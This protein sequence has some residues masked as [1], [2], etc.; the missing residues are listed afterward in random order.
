MFNLFCCKINN[1][2]RHKLVDALQDWCLSCIESKLHSLSPSVLSFKIPFNTNLQG[3][4]SYLH[5]SSTWGLWFCYTK[6]YTD[7]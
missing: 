4:W 3:Q 2:V 6:S 1:T 7:S 5:F